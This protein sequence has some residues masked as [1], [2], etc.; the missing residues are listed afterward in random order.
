MS[1]TTRPPRPGERNGCEYF[2]VDDATFDRMVTRKQFIEWAKVFG[3]RYGTSRRQIRPAQRQGQDVLLDIDVQGHRQVRRQLPEAMSIFL[4]PPSFTEL[5]R[6]LRRRHSDAPDVVRRRLETAS[7]EMGHWR[8][9]DYLIV[10]DELASAARA[11]QAVVL[12]ERSRRKRQSAAA[13]AILKTFRG[14]SG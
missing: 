5:K 11:L 3:H 6:R 9:Y 13:R 14:G 7:R 2:F 8:E 1:H 4:L 12:A 10:N